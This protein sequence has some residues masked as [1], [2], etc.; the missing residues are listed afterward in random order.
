MTV[1]GVAAVGAKVEVDGQGGVFGFVDQ[2]KHPSWWD[3]GVAPPRPGDKLHVCVLDSGREP[4]PRLSALRVDIGIARA[5]LSTETG[6]RMADELLAQ[7]PLD[8]LG[9]ALGEKG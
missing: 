4:Y 7:G 2:T 1:V 8:R 9:N 6:Q 3:E 5:R